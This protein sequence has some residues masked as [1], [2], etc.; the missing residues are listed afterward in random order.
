MGNIF[1]RI[2]IKILYWAN[3]PH[4]ENNG[5]RVDINLTRQP[6]FEK[7]DVYQK[8][9]FKRYEFAR[10]MLT[11]KNLCGDFAC[12]TGYGSIMLSEKAQ[13]VIGVDINNYVIETI[14]RRYRKNKKVEFVASNL[15][16]LRYQDQFDVIVSFET[17][18]HFTEN[19]IKLLFS[20]FSKALKRGGSLIFSTPYLQEETKEAKALGHHLTYNINESKIERWLL[21]TGFSVT[22]FKYQ[23]YDS[24]LIDDKLGKK[25]F[26]ICSAIK[27]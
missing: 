12:G 22:F 19:N 6:N 26:I 16:D 20:L 14:S 27:V 3:E 13:K 2:I 8:S 9:H 23:N 1:R 17:I 7:F 18:E 10:K 25:D 5:E 24:H 11:N 21:E 15:L 4:L